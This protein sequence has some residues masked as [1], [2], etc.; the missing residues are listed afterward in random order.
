MHMATFTDVEICVG[1]GLSS[2]TSGV[3]CKKTRQV[4]PTSK[5]S[6][7]QEKYRCQHTDG[8]KLT[9]GFSGVSAVIKREEKEL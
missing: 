2:V 5:K 9:V 3:H 7:I 6:R 1:L 8:C 4:A